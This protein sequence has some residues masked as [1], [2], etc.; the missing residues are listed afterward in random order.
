[1]KKTLTIILILIAGFGYSQNV[2]IGTTS[3]NANSMLEVKS[4]SKGILVPRM[5]SVAR[6][7]IPNTKGLI[8]YDS[9]TN[10][11]WFNTGSQWLQVG[12]HHYIGE[13]FGGGIIFWIDATGEHGLVASVADQSSGVRWYASAL[14][15][16]MA[17]GDGPG[18]GKSNS[19]II[20]AN[21]G[22]GDGLTYAARLCHELSIIQ[23]GI[24][25]S[26]WYL[27][28]LSE[29]NMLYVNRNLIGGFSALN[30]WSS[31]EVDQNL[32]NSIDFTNGVQNI[33]LK[34]FQFNI[35]AIRS[36]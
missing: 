27:P 20:I 15:W 3:P 5:D 33:Y 17:L 11:F 30:Y 21:Q 26:D 2:G 29:L 14:T 8:V 12:I 6:K 13:K 36:F 7:L 28:S 19:D 25:Y 16:T 35:R 10:S 34:N 9:T 18:A 23:N 31:T 4:G 24:T 1:M 32:C 22:Y